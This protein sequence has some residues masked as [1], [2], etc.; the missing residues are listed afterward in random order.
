MRTS[1]AVL[2]SLG[3]GLLGATAAADPTPAPDAHQM[4]T[5][6]CARAHKAGKACV[7]TIE[8][9][10]VDGGAP[11]AGEISALGLVYGRAS[12]LIHIRKDFIV[13]ILKTAED[14]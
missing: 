10:T 4:A 12:S 8:A 3:L 5:S 1:L 9:E 6:D 13:E 11:S 2:T 14:L 7:L